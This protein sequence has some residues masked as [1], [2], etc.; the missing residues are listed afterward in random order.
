MVSKGS[1]IVYPQCIIYFM[2]QFLFL[3]TLYTN[4]RD[5]TKGETRLKES[6]SKCFKSFERIIIG[7]WKGS[8]KGHVTEHE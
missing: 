7:I 2:S 6:M 3:E 5:D 8:R 1:L 4:H